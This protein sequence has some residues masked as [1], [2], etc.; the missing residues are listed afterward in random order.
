MKFPIME[1][2][3]EAVENVTRAD[4][5]RTMRTLDD[6][7]KGE[8]YLSIIEDPAL[9]NLWALGF[10]YAGQAQQYANMA[11]YEARDEDEAQQ[12]KVDAARFRRMSALCIQMFWVEAAAASGAE[13]LLSD[14]VGIRRGMEFVRRKEQ[15]AATFRFPFPFPNPE[16]E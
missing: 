16:G 4:I 15:P 9:I 11:L 14:S 7:T 2:I 8:T 13:A 1:Q 5:E 10:L 12:F 3:L 6:K